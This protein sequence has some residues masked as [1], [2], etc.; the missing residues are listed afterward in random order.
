M[1]ASLV[2]SGWAFTLLS[3]PQKKYSYKQDPGT[4]ARELNGNQTAAVHTPSSH[5]KGSTAEQR[6]YLSSRMIHSSMRPSSPL[7]I[8]SNSTHPLCHSQ[9]TLKVKKLILSRPSG[10]DPKAR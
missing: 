3:W 1:S 10:L 9:S 8:L 7:K 5:V 4:V 2:S 6:S